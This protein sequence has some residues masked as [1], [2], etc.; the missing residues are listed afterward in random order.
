MS[1]VLGFKLFDLIGGGWGGVGV[2]V[3]CSWVFLGWV[4]GVGWGWVLLF[5]FG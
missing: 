3:V 4:V 5:W 1:F 2:D